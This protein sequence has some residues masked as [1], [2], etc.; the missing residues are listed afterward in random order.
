MNLGNRQCWA[1]ATIG[2]PS[3][4]KAGEHWYEYDEADQKSSN[5]LTISHTCHTPFK[6][7]TSNLSSKRLKWAEVPC[8]FNRSR[9][10]QKLRMQLYYSVPIRICHLEAGRQ[11]FTNLRIPKN[12]AICCYPWICCNSLYVSWPQ[13][14]IYPNKKLLLFR[15]CL[16]FNSNETPMIRRL[17][18]GNVAQKPP[19]NLK[20]SDKPRNK[21]LLVAIVWERLR[22]PFVVYSNQALA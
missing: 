18:R 5:I 22:R 3:W 6:T 2:D 8:D 13:V 12:K 9:C 11:H 4:G 21:E 10:F 1:T 19:P 17:P 16:P 15:C 7:D 20:H 14:I